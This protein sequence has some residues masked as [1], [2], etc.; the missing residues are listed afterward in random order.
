MDPSVSYPA[1]C[2]EGIAL[3]VVFRRD[4][5]VSS[6]SG[7]VVHEACL[8]SDVAVHDARSLDPT[9]IAI[10]VPDEPFF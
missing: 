1:G 8:M 9:R 7:L 4:A 3:Y 10:L 5:R 6:E 2:I